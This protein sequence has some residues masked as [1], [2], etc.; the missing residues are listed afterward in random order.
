[1]VLFSAVLNYTELKINKH[2]GKNLPNA[3]KHN[4]TWICVAAHFISLE[5]GNISYIS[6]VQVSNIQKRRFIVFEV[7]G[8]L[9]SVHVNVTLFFPQKIQTI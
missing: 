8:C 2:V 6:T 1:V 9:L 3:G 4:N 7:T 5:A